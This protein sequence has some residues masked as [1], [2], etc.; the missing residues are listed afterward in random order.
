MALA[1]RLDPSLHVHEPVRKA[2]S[3]DE[4]LADKADRESALEHAKAREADEAAAAAAAATAAASAPDAAGGATS[5]ASDDSAPPYPDPE[6][7]PAR[8]AAERYEI[9]AR[10]TDFALALSQDPDDRLTAG[11]RQAA[12]HAVFNLLGNPHWACER[13]LK[14]RIASALNQRY[15]PWTGEWTS[16]RL[17][18]LTLSENGDRLSGT[19]ASKPGASPDGTLVAEIHG[20]TADGAWKSSSGEEGTISLTLHCDDRS[21]TGTTTGGD[22]THPLRATRQGSRP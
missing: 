10:E 20:R 17:D 3:T 14:A 5:A 19:W 9:L 12:L 15:L 1:R 8:F 2:M 16:D 6:D 11:T 7:L 21:I 13:Q 4:V 18:D 22:E